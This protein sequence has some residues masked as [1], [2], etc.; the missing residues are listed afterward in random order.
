METTDIIFDINVNHFNA[1][2]TLWFW[3][4]YF[5]A[6][7]MEHK[8]NTKKLVL[9]DKKNKAE[10]NTECQLCNLLTVDGK[11]FEVFQMLLFI[12]VIYWDYSKT[13][14]FF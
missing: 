12:Y 9:N 1:S 6:P 4:F 8:I 3:K 14:I 11:I 2:P 5:W 10:N 7:R 13:L